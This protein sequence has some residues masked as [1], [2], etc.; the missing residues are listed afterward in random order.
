MGSYP[1]KAFSIFQIILYSRLS[2]IY[3]FSSYTLKIELSIMEL[4]WPEF[5]ITR[6]FQLHASTSM[7]LPGNFYFIA[8]YSYSDTIPFN[9]Y[10]IFPDFKT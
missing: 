10:Y 8:R 4:Q 5:L 2:D 9:N 7:L 1:R 6:T 3:R